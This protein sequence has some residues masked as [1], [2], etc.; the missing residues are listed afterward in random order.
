MGRDANLG[1]NHRGFPWRLCLLGVRVSSHQCQVLNNLLGVLCL[2][3][4]RLSPEIKKK[5]NYKLV[6]MI[7]WVPFPDFLI[8][9]DSKTIERIYKKP[10]NTSIIILLNQSKDLVTSVHNPML[11]LQPFYLDNPYIIIR[12]TRSV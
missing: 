12:V 11:L 4:T 5:S 8:T 3:S 2:T 7:V 1:A 10:K 9:H 6:K